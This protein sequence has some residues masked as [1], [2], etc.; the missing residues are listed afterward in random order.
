MLQSSHEVVPRHLLVVGCLLEG[1]LPGASVRGGRAPGGRPGRHLGPTRRQEV[2]QAG[3]QGEK[4]NR[5]NVM[6]KH[7]TIR[8]L[9]C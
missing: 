3:C 1:S 2:P 9:M 8:I 4:A 7:V 5:K 6:V